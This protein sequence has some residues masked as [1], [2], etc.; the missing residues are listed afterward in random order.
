MGISAPELLTADHNLSDFYCQHETLNEWLARRA[1]KNNKLGASR[2]FVICKKGTKDVI[3]YYCLSAG[4][5][6]HIDA[7]PALKR[8]MPNPIPVILLGRL[9]VDIKYQG[10]KLGAL[11]LQDACKRVAST[12]EQIGI[13]AIIVHALDENARMF[14]SRL[15]FTQS[16]LE[17]YT[18]MLPLGR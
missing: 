6:H 10:Q 2:T 12:A 8:N 5:I 16:P 11:L 1:L 3:G 17:P 4:S 13:S 14:Y 18:L 15:G 7:I 9:A